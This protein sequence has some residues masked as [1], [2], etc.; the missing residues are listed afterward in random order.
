MK[1]S[2]LYKIFRP[3]V[4]VLFRI[5]FNP[6]IIN[7]EYINNSGPVLLVGNHTSNLDALL[8][9]TAVKRPIHFM[10]KSELFKGHFGFIFRNLGLISVD[11]KRKNPE[12]INNA[13]NYLKDDKVV[14][15]FPE[16][17]TEKGRGV[18]DFKLG[19]FKIA[20]DNNIKITPF[21]IKGKYRPFINNLLIEFL[22]PIS[23]GK[24]IDSE[25]KK[26]KMIIEN[27]VK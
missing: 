26:L 21:V 23:I 11:R 10:A 4:A 1:E 15:I 19:A 7:R 9:L 6:K 5:I 24:D 8:L 3:I 25:A 18:L 17:T 12:A 22:K 14:L 13:K 20:N 16:G 27:K 2:L